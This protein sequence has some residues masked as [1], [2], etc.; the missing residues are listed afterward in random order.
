MYCSR[1]NERRIVTENGGVPRFGYG[2]PDTVPGVMSVYSWLGDEHIEGSAGKGGRYYLNPA[3]GSE[4]YTEDNYESLCVG[5]HGSGP[6]TVWEQGSYTAHQ[7]R[8]MLNLAHDVWPTYY[9][10]TFHNELW[11]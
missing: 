9:P 3:S 11:Y 10:E 6:T 5:P 8:G 7:V 1:Y 4:I 2:M